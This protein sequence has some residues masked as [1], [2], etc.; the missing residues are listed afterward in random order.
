MSNQE[1]ILRH[2]IESVS[3]RAWET[4]DR[5]DKVHTDI[6][7]RV[8]GIVLEF[9]CSSQHIGAIRAGRAAFEKIPRTWLAMHLHDAVG[10]ALD[11]TDEWHYRRLLELLMDLMPDMFEHYLAAGLGSRSADIVAA[12]HEL[13]SRKRREH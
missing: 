4:L 3:P 8:L 12:A 7:L 9:A 11:L 6:S 2:Q 1:A 10:Q 5:L 13:K